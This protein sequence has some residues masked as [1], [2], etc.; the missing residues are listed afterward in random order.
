MSL[1]KVGLKNEVASGEMKKYDVKEN[2]M[3]IVNLG[4]EFIA[5]EDRCPHMNSLLHLGRLEDDEIVC[6]LHQARFN[7]RSGKKV[8]DPKISISKFIK[9]G[10]IMA[11]VKTHDLKKY[12]IKIQKDEIYIDL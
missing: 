11:N 12:E 2:E 6:P 9:A 5:F 4:G 1:I 8:S 3:T 7:I 10:S